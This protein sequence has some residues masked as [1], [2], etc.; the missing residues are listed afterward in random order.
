MHVTKRILS[1]I[2]VLRIGPHII[3]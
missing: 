1:T 2:R 3:F